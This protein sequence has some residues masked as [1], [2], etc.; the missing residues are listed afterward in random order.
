MN[1]PVEGLTNGIGIEEFKDDTSLSSELIVYLSLSN[2][3]Q[4]NPYGVKEK[5]T[6]MLEKM[7]I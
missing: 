1:K 6:Q 3:L 4:Q 7:V 5:D 2:F